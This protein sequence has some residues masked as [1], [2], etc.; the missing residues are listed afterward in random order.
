MF[1]LFR[2]EGYSLFPLLKEGEVVLCS[3][4]FSFSTIKVNDIVVF[5]KNN[6]VMIKKVKEINSKGYFVQGEN[7]DS[8]DSRNFGELQK[9]EILYKVLFNFT[10]YKFL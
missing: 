9:K 5:K 8:I 6:V 4:L 3:K 10:T 2:V 7:P 1:K